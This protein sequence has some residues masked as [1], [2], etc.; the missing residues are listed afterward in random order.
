MSTSETIQGLFVG[1]KEAGKTSVINRFVNDQFSDTPISG[2][3][4]KIRVVKMGSFSVRWQLDDSNTSQESDR[5]MTIMT[6]F[7]QQ[8]DVFFFVFDLSSKPSFDHVDMWYQQAKQH[9]KPT[10]IF[11]LVGAKSDGDKIVTSEQIENYKRLQKMLY[12]ETS[13]F[14][15]TGIMEMF[16]NIADRILER[17]GASS[18]KVTSVRGCD[19]YHTGWLVKKGQKW[20]HR[21]QNRWFVLGN[22]TID[23]SKGDRKDSAILGQLETSNII[24]MSD[25]G[26]MGNQYCFSISTATRILELRAEGK[27][28]KDMWMEKL[29]NVIGVLPTE[30]VSL[31][32]VQEKLS[33]GETVQLAEIKNEPITV[34]YEPISDI[35]SGNGTINIQRMWETLKFI[36]NG[37]NHVVYHKGFVSLDPTD[38]AITNDELEKEQLRQKGISRI[39]AVIMQY[40]PDTLDRFI[41]H[42]RVPLSFADSLMIM[43]SII[44]G[45]EYLHGKQIVHTDVAMNNIASNEHLVVRLKIVPQT[46]R[47]SS[48]SLRAK[49]PQGQPGYSAP[50]SLQGKVWNSIVD[51]FAFGIIC[52]EI[53]H[54]RA[55]F[56][57]EGSPHEDGSMIPGGT[58][59]LEPAEDTWSEV[60]KNEQLRDLMRKVTMKDPQKRIVSTKACA[61]LKKLLAAANEEEK[62]AM[63]EKMENASKK[64]D[65]KEKK[66]KK[67]KK[68][69]KKKAKSS[70]V[71]VEEEHSDHEQEQKEDED[72]EEEEE[73]GGE[74]GEKSIGDDV[75]EEN[76][77]KE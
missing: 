58:L 40:Y 55:A 38:N 21:W 30:S 56:Y 76:V 67:D 3:A 72:E 43:V 7:L 6:R 74:G 2:E 50:E 51:M 44:S 8:K 14:A 63:K 24:A 19:A 16:E 60:A 46:R 27:I 17:K 45:L 41:I 20:P 9:A 25:Q 31:K 77:D 34:H 47:L 35:L 42:K 53:V 13:S 18:G 10:A 4:S 61:T 33:R 28:I 66:N 39:P 75:A 11:V 70:K 59:P 48:S 32:R 65:K 64:K 68:K 62:A 15:N 23:Y 54:Q 36:G 37:S 29:T 71:A 1:D 22:E 5:F 49:G 26:V 12:Y 73:E 69:K 52:F 57:Y